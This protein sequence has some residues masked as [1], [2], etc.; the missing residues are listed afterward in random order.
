ML[1][2]HNCHNSDSVTD[3]IKIRV[4]QSKLYN[5]NNLPPFHYKCKVL[6]EFMSSA[7]AG[8]L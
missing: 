1:T 3:Y 4:R 2:Q 8:F 7:V 6:I 5:I